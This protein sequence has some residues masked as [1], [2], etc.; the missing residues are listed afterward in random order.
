MVIG[1]IERPRRVLCS[2]SWPPLSAVLTA[3]NVRLCRSP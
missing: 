2:I 3:L 1:S